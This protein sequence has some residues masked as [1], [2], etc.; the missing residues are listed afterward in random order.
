MVKTF[1]ILQLFHSSIEYPLIQEFQVDSTLSIVPT[2]TT[3]MWK[4]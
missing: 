2:M 4:Q 1:M 3:Q